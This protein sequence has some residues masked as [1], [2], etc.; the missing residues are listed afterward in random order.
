MTV[1]VHHLLIHGSHCPLSLAQLPR[2]LPR[3]QA[4]A[5]NLKL[6]RQLE[7][8]SLKQSKLEAEVESELPRV[9]Q[10]PELLPLGAELF[11]GGLHR[12]A[13]AGGVHVRG[14][15]TFAQLSKE[16]LAL[17]DGGGA[18]VKGGVS[19]GGELGDQ[20][21]C[22]LI[23]VAHLLAAELSF[24]LS[25]PVGELIDVGVEENCKFENVSASFYTTSK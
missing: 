7:G 6:A 15:S 10:L 21:L 8:V 1:Y 22:A 23:R 17:G 14:D 19:L 25:K 2:Q 4:L 20:P 18:R 16:G 9:P 24:E 13:G 5:P 12:S 3:L 11:E